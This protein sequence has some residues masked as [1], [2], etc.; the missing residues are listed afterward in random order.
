MNRDLRRLSRRQD[1]PKSRQC[2]IVGRR[3]ERWPGSTAYSRYRTEFCLSFWVSLQ[4][5]AHGLED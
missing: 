5:D 3:H 4:P 2:E 1:D